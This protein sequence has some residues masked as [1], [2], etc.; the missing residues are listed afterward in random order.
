MRFT[1]PKPNTIAYASIPTRTQQIMSHTHTFL[2]S[3]CN[4][5]MCMKFVFSS[6]FIARSPS[7]HER[8]HVSKSAI[9]CV[10][11]CS[12]FA[13][14]VRFWRQSNVC[15]QRTVKQQCEM[16]SHAFHWANGQCSKQRIEKIDF[17]SQIKPKH[18]GCWLPQSISYFLDKPNSSTHSF[19]RNSTQSSGIY[20]FT[21]LDRLSWGW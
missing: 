12:H 17:I 18:V 19:K 8:C 14:S 10:C 7:P 5:G 3:L 21:S 11:F 6:V 20:Y 1:V 4:A 16:C 13:H 2:Q 9:V 15:E